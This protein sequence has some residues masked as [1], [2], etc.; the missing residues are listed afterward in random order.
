M[1]QG[2]TPDK[3]GIAAFCILI[4]GAAMLFAIKEIIKVLQNSPK[5]Q[6]VPVKIDSDEIANK[7]KKSMNGVVA[8]T[9]PSPC[10]ELLTVIKNQDKMQLSLD[11]LVDMHDDESRSKTFKKMITETVQETISGLRG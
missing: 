9:H 5:K 3:I 1:L 10:P 11:N 4:G 2:M 6:D 7:I 8:N